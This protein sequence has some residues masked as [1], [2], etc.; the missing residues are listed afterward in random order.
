MDN[1]LGKIQKEIEEK[2]KIFK[3]QSDKIQS[4]FEI[5]ISDLAKKGYK[6]DK[7]K[8]KDF[9]L[10]F[11]HT[12]PTKN[13]NEWEVAVPVFI[14]FN[15]GWFDRAEGGYNVFTI[16]KYTQWLGETIPTFIL[17]E[18]NI[19]KAW[20]VTLE[21]N[22][23][24]FPEGSQEKI[25]DTFGKHLSLVEKNRAVVKQGHEFDLIAEIIDSG[26]LP[27]LP[28]PIA[29][30]DLMESDFTQVWDE[31]KEKYAQLD[32]FEGKYSFQGEAY[33]M[34]EKYGA[35]GVFWGMSFG[36]TVIGTYI[37]SRIKGRKA[38]VV[39]T[40][41]LEEHWQQFFKWNCPRLLNEVE[42]YT[43]QG[44]SRQKWDGLRKEAFAVIGFDECH[45]L[46]ADSFSKLGTIKSKYRF[47]L[48]LHPK[49]YITLST[50]NTIE[51]RELV[52]K[53]KRGQRIEILTY[54]E[55]E[56]KVEPKPIINYFE[57][58][59]NDLLKISIQTRK[60]IRKIV[61]S[62]D[63]KFYVEGKYIPASNLVI[64]S[65]VMIANQPHS[66]LNNPTKR[67]DVRQKISFKLRGK[68][69]S[70]ET[71][72]KLSTIN[73]E[74][75][76]DEKYREM[77]S[78]AHKGQKSY[79]KG[80]NMEEY[81]G[82]DKANEIKAKI[83]QQSKDAINKQFKELLVL[84]EDFEKR[85]FKFIPLVK[86]I[87][88]AI[89]IKEGKIFA[90]ELEHKIPRYEKYNNQQ[91]FDDIIWIIKKGRRNRLC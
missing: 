16:N 1:E 62:P 90:V 76:K 6:V 64:G 51:L 50:G 18:M 56:D 55:K 8:I 45:F 17:H 80:K 61:C 24:N 70:K 85:G 91:G 33:K 73:K 66:T 5:T 46:P 75:W 42:I 84:K 47:G 77:Q 67:R 52:E 3:L 53:L 35:I 12:Y 25:E 36:K 30:E 86:I 23:L 63:H 48:C 78:L 11:W 22:T 9:M 60:G 14:P 81:F 4:E 82:K 65:K 79:L 72:E 68:I 49:T 58:E 74:K 38:L 27:F 15:I 13:I 54:N 31:V 40:K 21:G 7:D 32:I 19:P 59:M 34:F 89:A 29:A 44:M 37:F 71:K 83:S 43:Y 88:D 39:P 26:S 41:T 10:K 87:P 28:K 57:K 69:V 20:Q 2:I